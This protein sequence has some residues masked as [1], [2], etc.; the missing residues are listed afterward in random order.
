MDT[1]FPVLMQP[2]ISLMSPRLSILKRII[3]VRGSRTCT[4][5][6]LGTDAGHMTASTSLT[7]S[8]VARSDLSFTRYLRRRSSQGGEGRW[9][10]WA[11]G[12]HTYMWLS[13]CLCMLVSLLVTESE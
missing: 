12:G 2:W 4:R 13:F 1:S 9:V 3:L 5:R 6:Q 7:C 8:T 11:G 10:E